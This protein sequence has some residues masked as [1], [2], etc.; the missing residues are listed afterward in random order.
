[1]D[2]CSEW[3]LENHDIASQLPKMKTDETKT[4]RIA[5][6][7]GTEC[8]SKEDNATLD[9]PDRVSE[10]T[11]SHDVNKVGTPPPDA[12]MNNDNETWE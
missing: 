4:V 8:R 12:E 5:E 10:T 6:A 2:V 3:N 7:T 9:V 11:G 1:M